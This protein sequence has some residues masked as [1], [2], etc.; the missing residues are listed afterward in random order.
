[1]HFCVQVVQI[2]LQ[3]GL[4]ELLSQLRLEPAQVLSAQVFELVSAVSQLLVLFVCELLLL[5][6]DLQLVQGVDHLL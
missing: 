4:I 2:R 6:V 1:M 5:P 3:I